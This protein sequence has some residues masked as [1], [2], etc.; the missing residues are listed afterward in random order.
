MLICHSCGQKHYTD[1]S[2][3][4]NLSEIKSAPLPKNADGVNKDTYD[5]PKKLKCYNCGMIFKIVKLTTEQPKEEIKEEKEDSFPTGD[6]YFKHWENEVLKS[7]RT[8]K[9]K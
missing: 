2:D 3:I 4:S 6:D 7:T 1:G 8:K 5:V 9:T